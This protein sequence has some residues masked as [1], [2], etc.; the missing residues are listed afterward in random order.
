MTDGGFQLS[1]A[2]SNTGVMSSYLNTIVYDQTLAFYPQERKEA[3]TV[4]QLKQFVLKLPVMQ[5][6]KQ[7]LS[8]R[9]FVCES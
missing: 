6:A 9:E 4:S 3:K 8:K 7:S 2:R 1:H 5:S